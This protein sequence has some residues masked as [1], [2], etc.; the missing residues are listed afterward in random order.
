MLQREGFSSRE[1][2]IVIKKVQGPNF[3]LSFILRSHARSLPHADVVVNPDARPMYC[4]EVVR[5]SQML[6]HTLFIF[7]LHRRMR[8]RPYILPSPHRRS[9]IGGRRSYVKR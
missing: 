4:A 3:T 7:V 2:K 6:K 9:A 1:Q 8:P 5:A